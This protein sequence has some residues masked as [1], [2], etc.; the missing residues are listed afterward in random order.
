MN[1]PSSP[2]TVSFGI[3]LPAMASAVRPAV[4]FL[5]WVILA[6]VGLLILFVL[7]PPEGVRPGQPRAWQVAGVQAFAV[8]ATLFVSGFAVRLLAESQNPD[9][10]SWIAVHLGVAAVTFA[11]LGWLPQWA[12]FV[13][14]A[15]YVV[16]AATPEVLGR[17]ANRR[18][19]AGYAQDAAF[20]WRLAYFFHPS[21][22]VHFASS[23][24]SAEALGSIEER[25]ARYRALA[26]RATPEQIAR[27][28]CFIPL[29]HGDWEGVLVQLRSAGEMTL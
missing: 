1:F 22:Y 2:G 4:R 25:V 14:V 21:A 18:R 10:K 6:F 11:A 13:A 15:T 24:V 20:Y 16:F 19:S 23:L 28:N 26:V 9:R 27:L 29:A 12:G 8:V 17:I 7:F 5:L 3:C